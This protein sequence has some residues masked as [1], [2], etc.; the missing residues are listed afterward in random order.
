M[1]DI[2][3][4]T[5]SNDMISLLTYYDPTD[6]LRSQEQLLSEGK[7]SINTVQPIG[8]L[9][10]YADIPHVF[11]RESET[12]TTV[13]FG[14]V[15]FF[16]VQGAKVIEPETMMI[17]FNVTGNGNN[18]DDEY[19]ESGALR[20]IEY[21]EVKIDGQ[22]I[23]RIEGNEIIDL[24]Y[25]L[26]TPDKRAIVTTNSGCGAI[27]ATR[28]SDLAT[29]R[30][31]YV[32]VFLGFNPRTIKDTEIKGQVFHN[33]DH[34]IRLHNN[35]LQVK[36]KMKTANEIRTLGAGAGIPTVNSATL[37][38]RT[39]NMHEHDHMLISSKLE[40]MRKMSWIDVETRVYPAGTTTIT[41]D[42]DKFIYNVYGFLIKTQT[43]ANLALG[44]D[45]DVVSSSGFTNL[46]ITKSN[47]VLYEHDLDVY[48]ENLEMKGKVLGHDTASTHIIFV[49][50]TTRFWSSFNDIVSGFVNMSGSKGFQ[51][52]IKTS[53]L[54]AESQVTITAFCHAFMHY[55]DRGKPLHYH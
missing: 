12:K 39:V 3:A 22:L 27:Q 52:K 13:G 54:A 42:L 37:S 33:S 9:E 14:N 4:Q 7:R 44:N 17:A 30:Y 10:Y 25:N 23:T 34:F 53:A 51:L 16:D 50:F 43:T 47:N 40:N 29:T 1:T 49:P 8:N 19:N 48:G 55:N 6:R 2:R 45:L 5:S 15:G 41:M 11:E 21:M 38:Y 35:K 20:F 31:F 26:A 24:Y 32:P 18:V 46:T 28:I 36:Y